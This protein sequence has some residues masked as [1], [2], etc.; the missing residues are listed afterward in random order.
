MRKLATDESRIDALPVT[1]VDLFGKALSTQA[2]VNWPRKSCERRDNASPGTSGSISTW[3][4]QFQKPFLHGTTRRFA[5]LL[6]RISLNAETAHRLAHALQE[7][8]RTDEAIQV[9]HDLCRI[10]NK[11]AYIHLCFAALLSEENGETAEAIELLERAVTEFRT[12][13]ALHPND[14]K[15]AASTSA[16]LSPN[17]L[18]GRRPSPNSVRRFVSSRASPGRTLS[19]VSPWRVKEN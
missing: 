6:R 7:V 17:S 1:S 10:K 18:N 14:E 5:I 2:R 11:N 8:N 16:G 13:L 15:A 19:L 9:F 4:S 12:I 3:R